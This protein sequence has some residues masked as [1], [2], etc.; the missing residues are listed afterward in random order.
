MTNPARKTALTSCFSVDSPVSV[1]TTASDRRSDGISTPCK[2]DMFFAQLVGPTLG[3]VATLDARGRSPHVRSG[4]PPI[5]GPRARGSLPRL[6]IFF[7]SFGIF[8]AR[9]L[10]A[11]DEAF[12][13]K[14]FRKARRHL[15]YLPRHRSPASS[16]KSHPQIDWSGDHVVTGPDE[17]GRHESGA[18]SPGRKGLALLRQHGR[19][20]T[21]GDAQS[22]VCDFQIITRSRSHQGPISD[23]STLASISAE[24]LAA[25][26]PMRKGFLSSVC[27]RLRCAPMRRTWIRK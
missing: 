14:H 5:V 12:L 2:G 21:N 6:C 4:R 7:H 17:L 16:A 25:Q 11:K 26:F 15:L 1:A 8:T 20:G 18:W 22:E 27:R 19:P 9:D 13:L 3:R 24:L 10:R 23:R